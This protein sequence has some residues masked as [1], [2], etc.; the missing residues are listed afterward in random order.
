M[1]HGT[2]FLDL[3]LTDCQLGNAL[4]LTVRSA[5]ECFSERLTQ[6]SN[7]KAMWVADWEQLMFV[8][9]LPIIWSYLDWP[10]RAG[11]AV[12]LI[13]LF[14]IWIR[15]T[16]E[17]GS[18][19]KDQKKPKQTLHQALSRSVIIQTNSVFMCI[20]FGYCVCSVVNAYCLSHHGIPQSSV[21]RTSC[22]FMLNAW[23]H[24][25]LCLCIWLHTQIF[26]QQHF[27]IAFL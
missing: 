25:V 9:P 5:S 27:A 19:P 26:V 15:L 4:T 14:L 11:S 8:L 18:G 1:R 21:W 23:L 24:H 6:A 2:S 16:L 13:K 10:H 20:Q 17:K 12:M 3:I 7:E 22:F